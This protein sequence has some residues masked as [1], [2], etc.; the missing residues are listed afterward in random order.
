VRLH[1]IMDPL[2]YEWCPGRT[3]DTFPANSQVQCTVDL[4]QSPPSSH[5]EEWFLILFT[6]FSTHIFLF[7]SSLLLIT[8]SSFLLIK[9]STLTQPSS[10]WCTTCFEQSATLRGRMCYN[11]QSRSS[12]K[13][14]SHVP[15]PREGSSPF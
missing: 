10:P 11:V 5:Q 8:S 14:I 9:V 7:Q 4:Q 3:F 1:F 12:H 6:R 2:E 15:F 13:D